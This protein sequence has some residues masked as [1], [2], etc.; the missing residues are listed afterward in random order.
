MP[1][2]GRSAAVRALAA[3]DDVG[4]QRQ[5]LESA[6]GL[7]DAAE[8]ELMLE[9]I[10]R[11]GECDHGQPAGVAGQDDGPPPDL[12]AAR[13]AAYATLSHVRDIRFAVA[14]VPDEALHH[15]IRDIA[16]IEDREGRLDA[17]AEI[18]PQIQAVTAD[19]SVRA[20]LDGLL[21]QLAHAYQERVRQLLAL[22]PYLAEEE[23]GQVVSECLEAALKM[24]NYLT[25]PLPLFRDID[26]VRGLRVDGSR[27]DTLS[28][29]LPHVTGGERQRVLEE[30]RVAAKQL[31]DE[32]D[33]TDRSL[34]IGLQGS[35]EDIRQQALLYLVPGLPSDEQPYMVE[36]ALQ[37][38]YPDV[39]KEQ[40]WALAALLPFAGD[41]LHSLVVS[42]VA[43]VP[44][45]D[46]QSTILSQL[47]PQLSEKARGEAFTAALGIEW[48]EH[49]FEILASLIGHLDG[50]QRVQAMEE[51]LQ[52][53]RSL[54]NPIERA[55][56][57]V[58][59]AR[60]SEDGHQ[61]TDLYQEALQTAYDY[62]AY[63]A[64]TIVPDIAADLPQ[65][66]FRQVLDAM[67]EWSSPSQ[68]DYAVALCGMAPHLPDDL[69]HKGLELSRRIAYKAFRAE[70]LVSFL[71][72][73]SREERLAVALEALGV[74]LL[75]LRAK[76][77]RSLVLK[78]APFCEGALDNLARDALYQDPDGV[79]SG[80][81][82]RLPPQS[83]A[84]R[85]QVCAYYQSL[86]EGIGAESKRE[87]ALTRI[88]RL[89]TPRA[90]NKPPSALPTAGDA[91]TLLVDSLDTSSLSGVLTTIR[92][93][94]Q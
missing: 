81:P 10:A 3:I 1:L 87:A 18:A 38:Q 2:S 52:A 23:R 30:I 36:L 6:Q 71:P 54:E 76:D 17:L 47:T 32:A 86:A 45:A 64:D 60:L 12:E 5:L 42:A 63:E 39:R 14:S 31:V 33:R 67:A 13:A 91:W 92:E 26:E 88:A 28:W 40:A 79:E 84:T 20:E 61:A 65:V 48:P 62:D 55:K 41:E 57:V 77:R 56:A 34:R 94:A 9:I 59:L 50:P 93:Q 68:D 7:T 85:R 72:R 78:V 58:R 16:V 90:D 70:A 22:L 75:A 21:T 4:V 82:L 49:R 24:P 74:G 11:A 83:D 29:L 35:E 69:L 66:L 44:W 19:R 27:A 25:S 43:A 15:E 46:V 89:C 73:L 53:A 37:A 51:G 8:R 80:A